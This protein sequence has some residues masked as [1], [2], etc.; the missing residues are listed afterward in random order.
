MKAFQLADT[1]RSQIFE[2]IDE[3]F[4][5][6]RAGNFR[7]ADVNSRPENL[8]TTPLQGQLHVEFPVQF[9]E[10]VGPVR[11][12][13]CARAAALISFNLPMKLVDANGVDLCV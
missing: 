7:V 10:W 2:A 9:D 3:S 11:D 6:Y 1:S 12:A 13:A 5:K 8:S 4:A